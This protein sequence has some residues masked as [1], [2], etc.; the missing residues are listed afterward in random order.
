MAAADLPAEPFTGEVRWPPR[1]RPGD[2]LAAVAPAGPPDRGRAEAGR[3]LLESWGLEVDLVPGAFAGHRSGFLAADDDRRVRDL[4]AAFTDDRVAGIVCLRGGYGSQRLLELLDF[5]AI[6]AHPK[7]FVGFSDVTA[8]H[9]A[10]RQRAGL[11]TFHG[12]NLAGDLRRIGELGGSALRAALFEGTFEPLQGEPLSPGRVR[13]PLVGGNLA[14]LSTL[15]GT[16]DALRADGC[17]LLLED[18][19]EAPYRLDRALT[20]LRRAG[21]LANVA[22]LAFGGF[23]DCVGPPG[24]A[25]ARDVAAEHAARLDRPAVYGLPLGH[26]PGQRTVAHGGEV[27]LDGDAGVLVPTGR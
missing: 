5:D 1:L 3:A 26:G 25:T 14:L 15:C 2:R 6:T 24:G 13:A 18:V 7:A 27:D 9:V 22:G 20:H 8:L 16:P 17:V 19:G 10:L 21:T 4:E 23:D 11:V 12:P